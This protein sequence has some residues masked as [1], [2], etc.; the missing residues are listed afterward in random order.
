MFLKLK[1]K[2]EINTAWL[3]CSA[4]MLLLA[5]LIGHSQSIVP[6]ANAAKISAPPAP[7]PAPAPASTLTP[8]SAPETKPNAA[9]SVTSPNTKPSVTANAE[10]AYD[11]TASTV[12]SSPAVKVASP[13][14]RTLLWEVKSRKGTTGSIVNTSNTIYLFGTIHVG[15]A[16]FYPLPD[17]VNTAFTNSKKLV[18]E[19]NIEDQKDSAEIARLSDYP[20]GDTLAKH[21]PP[22]LLARLK[23]VLATHKIPFENVATLRPVLLGGLLPIVELVKAG[24][25]MNQGLDIKLIERATAEKK[26]I[27]ELESSLAQIKLL[28]GMSPIMQEAFLANALTQSEQGKTAS[29][30]NAIVSAWREGDTKKIA[31]LADAAS[32]DGVMSQQINELLLAGRHPAMVD[33]LEGYLASGDSHFVAVGSLH[34]VGVGGLVEMLK[35]LG[36]SVRQL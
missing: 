26:P 20:P 25:E 17:A 11:P 22:A 10:G 30:V 5:P 4:L 2:I 32:R 29:Q 18:V 7:A 23:K 19:A 8:A 15:K 1:R 3:A 33:K 21:L 34:L 31:A 16:N 12:M 24:Y 6:P 27:L 36:Y 9:S 14:P 28:V 35:A 13:Q